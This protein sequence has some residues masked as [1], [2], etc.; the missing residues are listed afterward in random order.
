ME[1]FVPQITLLEF[2]PSMSASEVFGFRLEKAA[3][4]DP[5]GIGT[6]FSS[7]NKRLP[8]GSRTSELISCRFCLAPVAAPASGERTKR[9]LELLSARRPSVAGPAGSELVA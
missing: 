5:P 6:P 2:P 7:T 9:P 1:T 4:S 3:A 8:P